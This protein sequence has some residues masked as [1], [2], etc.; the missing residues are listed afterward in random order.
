MVTYIPLVKHQTVQWF[1]GKIE[2][3]LR[4]FMVKTNCSTES[5]QDTEPGNIA[6]LT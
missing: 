2:L 1:M 5:E 4:D 6:I 3:F